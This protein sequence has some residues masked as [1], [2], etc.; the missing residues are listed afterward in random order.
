MADVAQNLRTVPG[1]DVAAIA[2]Y[3]ATLGHGAAAPGA[4]PA[5][6]ETAAFKITTAQAI[7]ASGPARTGEQIFAATC[8]SCHFE[9]GAQPF[10]RPVRLALSSAVTGPDPRNFVQIVLRGIAPPPGAPGM[11]MPGFADALTDRQVAMLAD[12]V[13]SHFASQPAWSDLPQRLGDIRG[14]Q[15]R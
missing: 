5:R 3:V 8:A 4:P 6:A 11:M 7:K 2:A 9:G 12:Y 14:G 13:R 10:A 1:E 15:R